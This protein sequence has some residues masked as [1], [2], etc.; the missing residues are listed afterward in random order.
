MF[1]LEILTIN[2]ISDNAYLR[3]IILES[4]SEPLEKQP[5]GSEIRFGS[6]SFSSLNEAEKQFI[7]CIHSAMLSLVTD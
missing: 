1:Q 2:V 6:S 3:E 7:M 4:Y 5:Q